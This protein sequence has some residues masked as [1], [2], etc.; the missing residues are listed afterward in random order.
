L[1]RYFVEYTLD[2]RSDV[3]GS[4]NW[5]ESKRAGIGAIFAA[6]IE[7]AVQRLSCQPFGGPEVHRGVRRI[8]AKQ[9]PHLIFYRIEESRVVVLGVRHERADQASWPES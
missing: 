9:F 3:L 7:E 2:A 8:V 5:Y 6:R 4:K 1:K